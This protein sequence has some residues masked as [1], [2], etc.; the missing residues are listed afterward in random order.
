MHK[1]GK[2]NVHATQVTTVAADYRQNVLLIVREGRG[3]ALRFELGGADLKREGE[4]TV[5]SCRVILGSA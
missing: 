1:K 5:G 4:A 3:G 2:S